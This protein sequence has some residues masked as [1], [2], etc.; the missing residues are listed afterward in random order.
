MEKPFNNISNEVM[1]ILPILV[2]EVE[3]ASE[4]EEE[5]VVDIPEED[6]FGGHSHPEPVEEEVE[7]H[8]P[9]VNISNEVM[10]KKVKKGCGKRGPDKK[11][12]KKKIVSE[13]VKASLAKARE[14][15]MA[16]RREIKDERSKIR[17]EIREQEKKLI[18]ERLR[19]KND[20]V[21]P[22]PSPKGNQQP[23]IELKE[24]PESERER[25]LGILDEWHTKKKLSKRLKREN[26]RKNQQPHPAGRNIPQ[27][28]LPQPPPNPFDEIFKY[29]GS[30]RSSYW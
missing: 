7:E 16:K 23:T 13:A 19:A 30:N 24:K 10:V 26:E 28:M 29:K 8:I 15:S 6:V 1:E 4:V 20:P 3:E 2:E 18:T 21:T 22:L 14:A 9:V 17:L 27:T 5:R 12:R 11:P 25:M